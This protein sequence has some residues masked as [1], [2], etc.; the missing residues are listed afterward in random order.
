[1]RCQKSNVLKLLQI[2]RLRERRTT[3]A[4]FPLLFISEMII[5]GNVTFFFLFLLT[6]ALHKFRWINHCQPRSLIPLSVDIRDHQKLY[7]FIHISLLVLH[8]FL[9]PCFLPQ[10]CKNYKRQFQQYVSFL[11]PS[12][13]TCEVSPPEQNSVIFVL[14]FSAKQKQTA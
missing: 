7:I 13:V 14:I 11:P 2:S 5:H 9:L 10:K 1:M 6:F 8:F 4:V 3:A 12:Y